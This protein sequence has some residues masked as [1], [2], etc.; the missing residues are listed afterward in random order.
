MF[1]DT[2]IFTQSGIIIFRIKIL[3]MTSVDST[4]IKCKKHGKYENMAKRKRLPH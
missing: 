1:D 4:Q 2:V 3:H